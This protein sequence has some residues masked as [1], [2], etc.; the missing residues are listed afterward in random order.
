MHGHAARHLQP[1]ILSRLSVADCAESHIQPKMGPRGSEA[2]HGARLASDPKRPWVEHR[3]CAC[4]TRRLSW[5]TSERGIRMQYM[6]HG[7]ISFGQQGFI[8]YQRETWTIKNEN[9][10]KRLGMSYIGRAPAHWT[11]ANVIAGKTNA[12]HMRQT[13]SLNNTVYTCVHAWFAGSS[14]KNSCTTTSR[15]IDAYAAGFLTQ[16]SYDFPTW[17]SFSEMPASHTHVEA[18]CLS[19]QVNFDFTK[20][21]WC[22]PSVLMHYCHQQMDMLIILWLLRSWRNC[23]LLLYWHGTLK[24]W[25]HH[26]A[27]KCT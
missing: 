2:A 12:K 9:L 27:A 20:E 13:L 14:Q 10:H 18:W 8:L 19:L 5:K 3:C 11:T 26:P 24:T 6:C 25:I 4:S 15:C 1:G 16:G 7:Q 22:K 17:C 23:T 21:E